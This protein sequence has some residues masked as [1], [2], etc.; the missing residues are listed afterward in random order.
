MPSLAHFLSAGEGRVR[1]SAS[2]RLLLPERSP[3][4]HLRCWSIPRDS[5]TATPCTHMLQEHVYAQR[6]VWDVLAC[7]PPSTSTT[8]LG[9]REQKSTM[10]PLI[11]TWR[12]NFVPATWPLRSR[13]QSAVSASV[14]AR[15]SSRA[16]SVA[17]RDCRTGARYQA[18]ECRAMAQPCPHPDPLPR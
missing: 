4:V 13:R 11:G 15:R 6:P 14:I 7:C 8:S 12:R 10:N 5:R 1:A 16:L 9:L 17:R 3:Q 18:S 2:A